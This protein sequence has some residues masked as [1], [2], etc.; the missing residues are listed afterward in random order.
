MTLFQ[1]IPIEHVVL[2]RNCHFGKQVRVLAKLE[3]KMIKNAINKKLFAINC[4]DNW[5][6]D[7]KNSQNML[8]IEA[9][10]SKK[11]FES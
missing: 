1:L 5:K 6:S 10:K 7:F 4:H 2:C 3:M 9:N 8:N 11:F